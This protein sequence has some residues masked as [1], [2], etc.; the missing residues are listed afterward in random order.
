MGKYKAI[1]FD[2]DGT[3]LP[4][5]MHKFTSGYFKFLAVKLAPFGISAE[6]LVPAI[7]DG[8]GAMVKNDGSV[9]NDVM[10]WKRFEE[11]TGIPAATGIK[12][13]CDDF[14]SNEFMQAKQFTEENPLAVEAVRLAHKAAPI[15]ALATN[16][17]FPMC[18]QRSRMG[19]V[20]LSESDFD[21]VTSYE[22]DSF[23]K[24]NP[25]YFTSVC[26]RLGVKPEECLMVGNDEGEDMYAASLAGIK[27][28]YL[29]TDTMIENPKHPW[30]GPRGTFAE[31]IE[32]L[33]GLSE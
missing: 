23:C 1:L 26:E 15:V 12:D 14:Y 8:T 30:N 28:C 20:G 16:P 18:G 31:L 32:L 33:K 3:L 21:L 19:W 17:I 27:D 25:N 7:W 9:T 22:T 24:P 4:M 29:V 6:K 11:V 10:F 2:M 13:V 5:D